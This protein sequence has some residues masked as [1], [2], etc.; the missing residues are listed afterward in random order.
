MDGR[1]LDIMR[2]PLCG[3]DLNLRNALFSS[4][5]IHEGSL[6]CTLCHTQFPIKDGVPCLLG[7]EGMPKGTIHFDEEQAR[8]R[9]EE[10]YALRNDRYRT[11][12]GKA[13]LNTL[14]PVL[15]LASGVG[16]G[17]CYY[18][19]ANHHQVIAS[20]ASW[21]LMRGH[22][23][24]AEEQ[25]FSPFLSCI[26]T[27]VARLPFKNDS[28]GAVTVYSIHDIRGEGDAQSKAVDE[29]Y[30]CLR[31]G[32]SFITVSS[33]VDE[34]TRSEELLIETLP[35]DFGGTGFITLSAARATLE[36]FGFRDIY[37][38]ILDESWKK[39]SPGDILPLEGE[40]VFTY[41]LIGYK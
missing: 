7:P 10:G 25:G 28:L 11:T 41:L 13:A 19:A 37:F 36:S 30:R 1:L 4:G 18:L 16:L 14:G 20:D 29:A 34:G 8:Q 24:F 26:A 27:N 35:L 40:R 38:E 23:Q 2:C 22:A 21:P 15:D 6:N 33:G 5:L 31:S 9:A 12:L 39:A 17:A 32:G 3:G